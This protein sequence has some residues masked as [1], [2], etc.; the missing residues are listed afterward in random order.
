M[1]KLFVFIFMLAACVTATATTPDLP[2][3]NGIPAMFG[4][5]ASGTGTATRY[6]EVR[7]IEVDASGAMKIS[8]ITAGTFDTKSEAA[9]TTIL[10]ITPTAQALTSISDRRNVFIKLLDTGELWVFV[11]TGTAVVDDCVGPVT[12][13][14]SMDEGVGELI[15]IS[16]IGSTTFRVVVTQY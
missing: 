11:G 10:T 12:S 8:G 9:S 15:P 13:T 1:K 3:V 14:I 6:L 16:L 2:T 5:V 4:T 7:P